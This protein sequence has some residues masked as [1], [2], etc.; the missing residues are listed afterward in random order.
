[1]SHY[2]GSGLEP[3]WLDVVTFE[4][5]L[6]ITGRGVHLLILSIEEGLIQ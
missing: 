6:N 4:V 1:M 5:D 3:N 2:N